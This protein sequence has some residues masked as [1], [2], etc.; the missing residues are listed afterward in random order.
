MK[1]KTSSVVLFIGLIS[2]A[3]FNTNAAEQ[4]P[5]PALI[6]STSNLICHGD[7]DMR[8]SLKTQLTIEFDQKEPNTLQ[9]N[10]ILTSSKNE[11]TGAIY[12]CGASQ[13]WMMRCNYDAGRI[14]GLILMKLSKD[15]KTLTGAFPSADARTMEEAIEEG[16]KFTTRCATQTSR[17]PAD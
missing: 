2:M 3:V 4:N 14:S 5:I 11:S 9:A 6:K 13:D 16:F 10:Y 7:I 12:G 8:D 1:A 17:K 15:K